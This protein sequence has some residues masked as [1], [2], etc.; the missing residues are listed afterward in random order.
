VRGM[1]V[2]VPSPVDPVTGI[3]SLANNLYGWR[4]IHLARDLEREF[5][6]P[7]TVENDANMA[8]TG[9]KWRGVARGATNFVFVALGTGIGAG[10]FVDSK[11][12]RGRTGSAG[13]L[14]R[15]NLEWP[16]WQEDFGNTG[17]FETH[18]SGMGIAMHGRKLLVE[19]GAKPGSLAAERDAYF[20]FDAFRRGNPQ[21]RAVLDTV[22]TMLGVGIANVVSVIDPDLIVLGGGIVKGAPEFLLKTTRKVTHTVL[23]GL[24]PP[25][26]ISALQDK[27][28]TYGAIYSALV[29]AQKAAIQRLK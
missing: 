20:V 16:R 18:V 25:I 27:A 9:E 15:M 14:F 7:V 21:A 24:E 1:A 11:L 23:C 13:E 3:V 19:S 26:K 17:Y 2:G 10:V 29:G 28:Q 4:N 8:A 5:R 12:V 22:F 6:V